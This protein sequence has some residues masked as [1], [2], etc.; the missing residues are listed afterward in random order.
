M[1]RATIGWIWPPIWT[2]TGSGGSR[3]PIRSTATHA[4]ISPTATSCRAAE[5]SAPLP[6]QTKHRGSSMNRRAFLTTSAAS[7]TAATLNAAAAVTEGP[8]GET[9]VPLAAPRSERLPLGPLPGSRYPDPHI[10]ALDKKRFKGSV[11]TGAVERVA[12]GFR[13]AEG[14]AY[15]PRRPL[16]VVQRHPE[17]P[18][19]APA[20]GRQPPERVPL[21]VVQLER[22]HGRSG[23]ASASPANTAGGA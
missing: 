12:T 15:F 11:G 23:G 1:R 17:Q 16:P 9:G 21:A 2:V 22:Q 5:P 4:A 8:F 10:E 19:D 7:A 3:P 20:G 13:W 6:Q 18:D 14:P